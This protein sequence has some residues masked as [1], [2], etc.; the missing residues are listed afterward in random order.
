MLFGLLLYL[1]KIN[2]HVY[3]K[4]DMYKGRINHGVMCV[5]VN[6]QEMEMEYTIN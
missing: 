1:N 4:F 6:Y 2:V 3:D 5:E